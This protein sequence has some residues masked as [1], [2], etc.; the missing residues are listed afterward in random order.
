VAE[1]FVRVFGPLIAEF[2]VTDPTF[3]LGGSQ[4]LDEHLSAHI[5][6]RQRRAIELF[7]E[8][9]GLAG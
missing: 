7:S 9:M 4:L 3:D 6:D 8:R 2:S 1:L 5:N